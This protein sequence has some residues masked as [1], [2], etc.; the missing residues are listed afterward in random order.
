MDKNKTALI[1]KAIGDYHEIVE[2]GKLRGFTPFEVNCL[3]FILKDL[4]DGDFSGTL[5][6]KIANWFSKRGFTVEPEGVGWKI[7]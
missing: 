7:Q 6:E 4:A 1:Q 2:A 3:W 5:S